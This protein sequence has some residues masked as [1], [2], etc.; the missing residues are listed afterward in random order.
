[1]S[2]LPNGMPEVSVSSI[3]ITHASATPGTSIALHKLANPEHFPMLLSK[4]LVCLQGLYT[5][6]ISAA[7]RT[8]LLTADR[9]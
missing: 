2:A 3:A 6:K 5:L 4:E 1:M 9:Q 8:P 7:R